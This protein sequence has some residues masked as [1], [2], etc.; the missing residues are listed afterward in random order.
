MKDSEVP[1]GIRTHT[2]VGDKQEPVE[3]GDAPED[4]VTGKEVCPISVHQIQH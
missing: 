2:G 3:P 4:L 1:G